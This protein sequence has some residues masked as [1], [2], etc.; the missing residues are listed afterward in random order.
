MFCEKDRR[1]IKGR[2]YFVGIGKRIIEVMDHRSMLKKGESEK[3]SD[4]QETVGEP[5]FQKV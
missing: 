4:S 1:K 5:T 2:K 3:G